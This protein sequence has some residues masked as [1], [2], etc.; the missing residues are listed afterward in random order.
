M[1]TH[2]FSFFWMVIDLS[3]TTRAVRQNE[4]RLIDKG[5]FDFR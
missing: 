1:I 3:A 5:A 2:L 4:Q